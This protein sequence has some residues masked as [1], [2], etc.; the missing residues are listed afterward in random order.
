MAATR[1][2][3]GIWERK[4]MFDAVEWNAVQGI[5]SSIG[6]LLAAIALLYSMTSFKKTLKYVH[7]DDIDKNY[8]ELVKIA[9]ENP[10]VRSPEQIS[11]PQEAEKYNLYAFMMWNFLEAI[12][13]RCLEDSELRET[14][15]PIIQ[16]EG[17]RHRGWLAE[18]ENAANFKSSF[19]T[20][21]DGQISR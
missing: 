16:S 21:V 15:M 9:F 13:D 10:Y 19:I 2:L 7:Y 20:Y 12:H 18:P 17:R 3:V 6:T 5:T 8:F 11:A 14:W 4:A 1:R